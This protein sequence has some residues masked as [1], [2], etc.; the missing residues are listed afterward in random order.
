MSLLRFVSEGK[1]KAADERD[2]DV[3][4]PICQ[5]DGQRLQRIAVRELS[6]PRQWIPFG[7]ACSS[8]G[9]ILADW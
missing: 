8:C 4:A 2:L 1:L 9:V 7:W 6:D 3:R 5:S